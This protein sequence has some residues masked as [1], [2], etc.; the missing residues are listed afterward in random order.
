MRGE[1]RRKSNMPRVQEH[2]YK[3]NAV[4]YAKTAQQEERAGRT[5]PPNNEC[6]Y[7]VNELEKSANSTHE[8]RNEASPF[9]PAHHLRPT[10]S[11]DHVQTH[12]VPFARRVRSLKQPATLVRH[13]QQNQDVSINEAKTFMSG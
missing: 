3:V 13:R 8:K 2:G 4:A 12:D 1:A 6:H 10:S 5:Y 7:A 9:R 11:R